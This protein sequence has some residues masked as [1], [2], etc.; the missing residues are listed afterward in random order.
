MPKPAVLFS[1]IA[2]F[3]ARLKNSHAKIWY[4]LIAFDRKT[5]T[6]NSF[7]ASWRR[8][9]WE[10]TINYAER[11]KWYP[12]SMVDFR[13]VNNG[14][15]CKRESKSRELLIVSCWKNFQCPICSLSSRLKESLLC[16]GLRTLC[17][18]FSTLVTLP[19]SSTTSAR[20]TNVRKFT[21][22]TPWTGLV[23][24]TVTTGSVG[25]DWCTHIGDRSLLELEQNLISLSF[26]QV[27]RWIGW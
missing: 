22:R 7:L 24:R 14:L 12:G 25:E 11:S 10:L 18:F 13:L 1:C 26:A 5:C 16:L 8:C 15:F 4:I 6:R 20:P 17:S 9:V 19:V 21:P 27:L 3:G 2:P 23:A